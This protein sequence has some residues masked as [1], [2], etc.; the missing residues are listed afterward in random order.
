ME[1]IPHEFRKNDTSWA[2]ERK[3]ASLLRTCHVAPVACGGRLCRQ[4]TLEKAHRQCG[5]TDWERR[6][7]VG[8]CKECGVIGSPPGFYQEADPKR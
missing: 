8:T 6:W 2:E 5:A 7:R 3:T 1:E 4:G